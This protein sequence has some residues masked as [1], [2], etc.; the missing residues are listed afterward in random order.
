MLHGAS[1]LSFSNCIFMLLYHSCSRDRIGVCYLVEFQA[2]TTLI[3]STPMSIFFLNS[4]H[5]TIHSR[6]RRRNGKFRT[7][8]L[9]KRT[10]RTLPI[11]T[12]IST[13][14]FAVFLHIFTAMHRTWYLF[15]IQA[16][17][18]K[19]DHPSICLVYNCMKNILTG[20]GDEY[21]WL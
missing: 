16:V 5:L 1:F 2:D 3:F 7:F 6:D 8:R 19:R 10:R 15:I 17:S 11:V 13:I 4:R 20:R 14:S 18:A 21:Q 9:N 12:T